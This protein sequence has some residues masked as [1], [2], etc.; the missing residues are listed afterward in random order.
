M[1]HK[2]AKKIQKLH[3]D[4]LQIKA[5]EEKPVLNKE[6]QN[7][8]KNLKVTLNSELPELTN[9]LKKFLNKN[10]KKTKKKT[11]RTCK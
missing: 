4:D 7:K 6:E 10:K 3:L 9:S 2:L 11:K 5:L 8:L 1:A